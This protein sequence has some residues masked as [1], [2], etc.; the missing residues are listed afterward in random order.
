MYHFHDWKYLNDNQLTELENI[1][2]ADRIKEFLSVA[3]NPPYNDSSKRAIAIDFHFYNYMYCMENAYD[4]RKTSTFMS[5]MNDVF[6]H[7]MH[8]HDPADGIVTSFTRFKDFLIK[9]SIER[10]P[11]RYCARLLFRILTLVQH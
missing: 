4:N 7:D 3:L 10:P 9:H 2:D 1:K 5:I 6:L 8:T 11:K